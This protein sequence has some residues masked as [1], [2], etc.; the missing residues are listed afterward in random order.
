MGF[1][2]APP[3]IQR[4]VLTHELIHIV[5]RDTVTC[6]AA[7]VLCCLYWINPVIW[8]LNARLLLEMEQ[9]CDDEA[10]SSG[11]QAPDYASH[12]LKAIRQFDA[13]R[14]PGSA[15][16][17]ARASSINHRIRS[18]LNS[19]RHRGI[20]S[21]SR[22][23]GIFSALL[24]A[25]TALGALSATNAATLPSSQEALI[26]GVNRL[27]PEGCQ[28]IQV[29]FLATGAVDITGRCASASRVAA[30][31]RG[32]DRAGGKPEL[33]Q[34]ETNVGENRNSFKLRLASPQTFA[35]G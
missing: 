11:I 18:L 7:R 31:M 22:S 17:M 33:E 25:G 29:S 8:L 2:A 12:L 26:A 6:L 15:V 19:R 1:L 10:V 27:V 16:A 4:T 21:N 35:P 30:F 5:R 28:T 9:S 3:H 34:L 32:L 23:V 14:R 24:L 20:M 13:T